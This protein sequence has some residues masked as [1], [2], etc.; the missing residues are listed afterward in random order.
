[1][2]YYDMIQI[3]GKD[4]CLEVAY[5]K[6]GGFFGSKGYSNNKIYETE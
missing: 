1:M 5:N 2:S 3:T 4:I 6:G